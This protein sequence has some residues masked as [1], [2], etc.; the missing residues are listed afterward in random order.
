MLVPMIVKRYNLYGYKNALILS[1]KQLSWLSII[2]FLVGEKKTV[3]RKNSPHYQ[4][5]Q[6]VPISGLSREQQRDI[7]IQ[8]KTYL[9]Y[10]IV[11]E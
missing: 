2:C 4:G 9:R 7:K 6:M 11:N 3:S 1:T 8:L 5:N 10:Q